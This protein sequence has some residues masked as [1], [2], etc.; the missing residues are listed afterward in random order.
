MDDCFSEIVQAAGASDETARYSSSDMIVPL[1]SGSA[2]KAKS[3]NHLVP[4]SMLSLSTT[5]IRPRRVQCRHPHP[6][7][8]TLS[9]EFHN[10]AV[11]LYFSAF[12]ATDLQRPP[13]Y[14]MTMTTVIC[15]VQPP[16]VSPITTT[17]E[18]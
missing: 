2:P 5:D 3:S 8:C 15:P 16:L 14:P 7:I 4:T 1:Q 12:H 17:P 10:R 13:N 18:R 11:Q 6:M 9:V